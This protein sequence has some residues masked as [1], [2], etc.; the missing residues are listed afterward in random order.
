MTLTLANN[1]SE[2]VDVEQ[3]KI[4]ALK[5]HMVEVFM[6]GD[7]DEYWALSTKMRRLLA[8]RHVLAAPAEPGRS[9]SSP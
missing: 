7:L 3:R 9:A 6:E 1:Q 8:R 4:A 2:L 5:D